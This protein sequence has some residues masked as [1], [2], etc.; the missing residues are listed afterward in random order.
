[1]LS[2]SPWLVALLPL[3]EG[4]VRQLQ[5]EY[6]VLQS[7]FGERSFRYGGS[8]PVACRG[9]PMVRSQRDDDRR[10]QANGAGPPAMKRH[11]F[12]WSSRAL[13]A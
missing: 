12:R 7:D 6:G 3:I 1:M 5:N 10:R 8:F 9:T 13:Q 2:A 4:N 11:W